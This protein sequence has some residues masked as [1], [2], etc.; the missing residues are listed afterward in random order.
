MKKIA[1]FASGTGSN[2]ERIILHFENHPEVEV[3]VIVCNNPDAGVVDVATRRGV[4]LL[5]WSNEDFA[6]K[7]A[8]LAREMNSR[9]I[10]LI[11]L[12]GFLRKIPAELISA[13]EKR[14]INIH[15]ALLPQFG[16]KGMYGRKVHEAVIASGEKES[17]ITVHQVSEQYDE[18][19]IVFQAKCSIEDGDD[20]VMLEKKVRDLEH[21]YFPSVIEDYLKTC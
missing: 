18:G 16:G 9:K 14:I 19:A 7:G 12:A 10:D 21:Q 4:E 6:G 17:G 8:G 1:V 5:H 13:Y 2:A 15:P 3:R 20:A 11:V